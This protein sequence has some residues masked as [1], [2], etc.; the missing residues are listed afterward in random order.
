MLAGL[1]K[2]LLP[3]FPEFPGLQ[4]ND[5]SVKPTPETEEMKEIVVSSS[6]DINDVIPEIR[7]ALREGRKVIIFIEQGNPKKLVLPDA[8]DEI[9]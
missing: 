1:K 5:A 7:A 4:S 9:P 6:Q 3:E 2:S 8:P